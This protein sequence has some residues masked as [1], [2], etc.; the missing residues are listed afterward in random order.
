MA[1][2]TATLSLSVPGLFSQDINHTITEVSALAGLASN[3]ARVSCDDNP[4]AAG[5]GVLIPLD[6]AG[7]TVSYTH[8]TLPTPPYV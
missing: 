6:T 3:M 5:A 2:L 8:L 1:N 7:L 4:Q